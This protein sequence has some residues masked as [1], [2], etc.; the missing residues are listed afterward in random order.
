MGHLKTFSQRCLS[1]YCSSFK[2]CLWSVKVIPLCIIGAVLF[3][4]FTDICR[5]DCFYN[6]TGWACFHSFCSLTSNHHWVYNMLQ[7][8]RFFAR[9]GVG[10]I[11]KTVWFHLSKHLFYLALN[12]FWWDVQGQSSLRTPKA[13]GFYR[14]EISSCG[15]NSLAEAI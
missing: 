12:V 3:H 13:S 1:S 14:R 8:H 15:T 9:P 4:A 2:C 11:P 7:R 10:W 6:N 5:A